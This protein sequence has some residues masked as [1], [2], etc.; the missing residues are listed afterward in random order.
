MPSLPPSVG[1]VFMSA[2]SVERISLSPHAASIH[3]P[4]QPHTYAMCRERSVEKRCRVS[5]GQRKSIIAR[6]VDVCV[7]RS[8][9][10]KGL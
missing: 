9:A 1:P 3:S 7:R 8:E 10:A 5:D 4:A 2:E 6:G